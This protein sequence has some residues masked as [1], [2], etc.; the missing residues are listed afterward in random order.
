M[1]PADQLRAL[2]KARGVDAQTPVIA[3]CGSG[4]TAAV[5]ALALEVIG[6]EDVGVYDGS[7]T[8][9]GREMNDPVR[10]PATAGADV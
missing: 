6:H 10:F 8:E 4:V 1:K 5:I 7:W 9:W 3:T 2:F